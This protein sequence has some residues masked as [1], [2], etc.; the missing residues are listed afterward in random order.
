MLT[1]FTYLIVQVISS[2]GWHCAFGS[3]IELIVE[4]AY[5]GGTRV[6]VSPEQIKMG[7]TSDDNALPACQ[8][9]APAV[10]AREACKTPSR[11]A[12]HQKPFVQVPGAGAS[13]LST[14][15]RSCTE[16]GVQIRVR[17]RYPAYQTVIAQNH[18][19]TTYSDAQ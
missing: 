8:L 11:L 7:L 3:E 2:T 16:S 17:G 10:A 19:S 14:Y 13:F 12:E 9:A 4:L 1:T 5:D 15:A 18:T 6:C